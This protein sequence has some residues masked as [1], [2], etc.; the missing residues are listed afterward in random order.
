[1][2]QNYW[3]PTSCFE[4]AEDEDGNPEEEEQRI[5]EQEVVRSGTS[6]P[7]VTNHKHKHFKWAP[8]FA[9]VR[10]SVAASSPG[11]DGWAVLQGFTRQVVFNIKR[12]FR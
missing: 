4:E 2:L 7:A 3:G 9:D 12:V 11:N 8:N 6:S 1:M 5:R 10:K